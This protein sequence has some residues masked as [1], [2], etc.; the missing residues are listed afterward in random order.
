MTNASGLKE[1][2]CIAFMLKHLFDDVGCFSTLF[3]LYDQ[4]RD[5]TL[6][7]KEVWTIENG[8]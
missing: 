6:K 7:R 4:G 2:T 1:V 3:L 8:Q 5:F